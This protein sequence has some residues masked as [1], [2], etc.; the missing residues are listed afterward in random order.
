MSDGDLY[1]VD[2][3]NGNI[4]LSTLTPINRDDQEVTTN[5]FL[6]P[7]GSGME[8]N[9]FPEQEKIQYIYTIH[10][11]H[12]F[13]AVGQSV[14]VLLLN[15]DTPNYH[16]IHVGHTPIQLVA[17]DAGQETYLYILYE[18]N[19]RGYVVAYRKY[20]NGNWGRH[21]QHNVLVY[22]PDWFDLSKMSNVLFFSADDWH[23]SYK[24]TYVA[25]AIDYTI[26][27][28]EI[29]DVFDFTISIPEPC[30]QILSI[31]FN[32]VKQTLFVVCRNVT[33]YFSYLDYQLYTSS[34]WN[35]TGLTYFTQ[36]GRIAAIA[37]NHS[38]GMTTVTVHGLHF[39]PVLDRDEKVYEFYH[40]HHVAS[41]S[42]II[43]GEFITVSKSRHYF[44]YI[45]QLEF[46][47]LCIDVER[48]LLNVRTEGVLNDATLILPNTHSISCT[49]YTHCPVMYS[50]K[51]LL[52]AQVKS[53]ETNQDCV[54][55][56]MLFNMS[57]LQ[58]IANI[59]GIMN[60][61]MHAYKEHSQP[62]LISPPLYN[63]TTVTQ[64]KPKATHTISPHISSMPSLKTPTQTPD[65]STSAPQTTQTTTTDITDDQTQTD[66]LEACQNDLI[67]TNTAYNQL[68]FVSITLC[69]CFCVAML[70]TILILV[71]MLCINRREKSPPLKE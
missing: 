2:I 20:S 49:S 32:E 53:C 3:T 14:V 56:F 24:V 45:E 27:F 9:I 38:G 22:S 13:I 58:N 65:Y 59:T 51:D 42:L 5:P 33:F 7:D 1:A 57:S 6:I 67:A 71:I 46:G 48:A 15:T 8:T 30:D 54:N 44:C 19:N 18:N 66:L 52:V 50:H 69:V 70:I 29:L 39:E 12:T 55:L 37:T 36:D 63:S 41:R 43:R 10:H 64:N 47:I 25:V 17:H 61:G 35:R 68:L 60:I 4:S 31:N 28:K 26:Y 21:G 34:L 16:H 23:Y 11:H 40:F 62:I